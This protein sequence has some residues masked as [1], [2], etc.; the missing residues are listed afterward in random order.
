MLGSVLISF[1]SL[2]RSLAG[3][4]FSVW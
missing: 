1:R 4:S 2:I 3:I